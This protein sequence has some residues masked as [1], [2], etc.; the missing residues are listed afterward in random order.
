METFKDRLYEE[1]IELLSKINKLESFI[2]S[3]AFDKIEEVQQ[4]LLNIQLTAMKT[5]S[6]C[7][8]ERLQ[9]LN[10]E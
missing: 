7:L 3:E 6:N 4:A 5:Y 10:K 1:R 8:F 2:H 9:F